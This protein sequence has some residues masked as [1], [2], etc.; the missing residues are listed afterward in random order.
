MLIFLSYWV[1][2]FLFSGVFIP[3]GDIPSVVSWL[4]YALPN[5]H[6]DAAFAFHVVHDQDWESCNI[7]GTILQPVCVDFSEHPGEEPGLLVLDG[8]HGILDIIESE[9]NRVM[10]TGVVLGVGLLAKA[11]YVVT[12]VYKCSKA[13]KVIPTPP[14]T[15]LTE[16]ETLA[17][18]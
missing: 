14:V 11:I 6:F 2:S 7:S 17:G 15:E 18:N 16:T 9:D 12:L 5:S 8:M 4:Y 13:T 3:V 10:Q 1:G